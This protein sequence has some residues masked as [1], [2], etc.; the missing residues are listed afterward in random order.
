MAAADV[1]TPSAE[2]IFGRAR[3][4]W[5]AQ[6]YPRRLRYVVA[7][8]V[9][10]GDAIRI[11]HYAAVFVPSENR[12]VVRRFSDEEAANPYVSRGVDVRL[13]LSIAMG[14]SERLVTPP[15]RAPAAETTDEL[16]VPF[17]DPTYAFGLVRGKTPAQVPPS[18]TEEGRA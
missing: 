4:V 11:R 10:Q 14:G 12:L 2:A 3:E 18:A 17:L 9:R 1:A 7:V 6:A 5:T 15:L 16:G 8:R 13:S